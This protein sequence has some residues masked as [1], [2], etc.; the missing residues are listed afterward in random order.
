ML[1]KCPNCEHEIEIEENLSI[2]ECPYCEYEIYFDE[3]Y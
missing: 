3:I 2:I 1:V